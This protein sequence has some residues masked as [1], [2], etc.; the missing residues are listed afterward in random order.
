M[1]ICLPKNIVRCAYIVSL[2]ATG[3]YSRKYSGGAGWVPIGFQGARGTKTV[4]IS[5]HL[6][7][8]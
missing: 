3:I 4:S 6:Y 5:L 2:K 1:A 7:K 8:E